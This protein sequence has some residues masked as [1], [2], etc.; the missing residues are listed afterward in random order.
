SFFYY[1]RQGGI[2]MHGDAV[3]HIN[4]ARR[5]VDSLY[6][7]PLQL[8]T[9]WLPLPHLLMLPFIWV[10]KLWQSGIAGSIPS[11]VAYVFGVVGVFRLACGILEAN[12]G[13]PSS[14]AAGGTR[15]SHATAGGL[16]AAFVYGANPNLLYMQATAL[17]ETLF[18]GFFIWTLVFF[19]DFLHSLGNE[20]V[21]SKPERR[22]LRKCA[23]CLAAAEL[24]RY[25]GWFLAGAIGVFVLIVAL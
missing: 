12:E 14:G 16:F 8:G 5:V 19:S 10:D 20:G 24:S 23:W 9:V 4:I 13:E 2:L 15:S 1:L 7:G 11:M 21:G 6:P 25:D 18:L 3:A 17:T 22:A